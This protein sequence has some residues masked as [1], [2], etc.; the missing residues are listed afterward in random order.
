NAQQAI[1]SAA[2][3][4]QMAGRSGQ[5]TMRARPTSDGG[6]ELRV[7][8]NGPG[9]PPQVRARLFEPFFTTK[10]SGEGT[11]LGLSV[12]FGIIQEHKG[13][14]RVETEEGKG[15]TFVI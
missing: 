15:T 14:I 2:A 11:G 10:K 9:M 4:G 8:D 12:S 13:R 6:V 1:A 7:I 5:V 3:A